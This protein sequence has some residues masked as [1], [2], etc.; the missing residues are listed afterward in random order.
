MQIIAGPAV[1]H[2]NKNEIN[3]WFVLDQK[4]VDVDAVII[5]ATDT[6]LGI[7]TA[8]SQQPIQAGVKAFVYL[9]KLTPK[10][11]EYPVDQLLNYDLRIDG[12][13][14]SHFGLTQGER[15][16]TY[17]GESLPG[18]VLKDKH[19]TILQGSCRKPHAA[20]GRKSQ[21]D[22]MVTGDGLVSRFK[23][24]MVNRP[25]LLFLTG[26]QIYADD[27]AAPLMA[28]IKQQIK[29]YIGHDEA[30]PF[31]DS[32]PITV[33]ALKLN[34]RENLLSQTGLGFSSKHKD[35]QLLSFAEYFIMYCIV[36]GGIDASCPTFVDVE[37]DFNIT[38]DEEDDEFDLI[39]EKDEVKYSYIRQRKIVSQFLT[40]A[41]K[42]RRLM[43]NICSYMI[44]DD[45]EVSD[46]WNLDQHNFNC[47][48]HHVF[49][50]HVQANALAAYWLC[51]GWG[52]TPDAFDQAG[53][54]TPVQDYLLE[55]ES[56]KFDGYESALVAHYWGY[57]INTF[58]YTVVLDTRTQ[59]DYNN[60]QLAKLIRAE[61]L[62]KISDHIQSLPVEIKQDNA[63]LLVSPVPVYGFNSIEW[64]QL[65]LTEDDKDARALDVESWIADDMAF[66]QVQSV[67]RES[68]F[69][70]CAIFSGDV[71]YGFCR[72][73]K[74]VSSQGKAISVFQLT[75]SS[76]HNA[77]G[78]LGG[79]GLGVIA[80]F[81][82]FSRHYSS[83][84]IPKDNPAEFINQ[85]TNI[86]ILTL[87]DGQPTNFKL[88]CSLTGVPDENGGYIWEYDLVR[89]T[90]LR[91]TP[92]DDIWEYEDGF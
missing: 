13:N 59:R 8:D 45:H 76:L 56:T 7:S 18:I 34:D 43:A 57:T 14:L 65:A 38:D 80:T 20:R 2:A 9:L 4:A 31:N 86:G 82:A 44:F 47:F 83:Y 62:A 73:E 50:R 25:T 15:A 63:L 10:A 87:T 49:S 24:D 5:Q 51:Q 88:N 23:S 77:P 22:R 37:N 21:P 79:I 3:I 30:I 17:P 84:L 81:E 6:V 70:S 1:R 75:S 74:L 92:S 35:N 55:Y 90:R 68:G 46:D 69:D 66:K 42:T 71:H 39:T 41:W 29:A 67:I 36:W 48:R 72:H 40:Q 91:Q 26:D 16:I 53:F 60:R 61:H 32:L 28:T 19:S 12:Q 52:N 85:A 64:A 78:V 27:V 58:P 11:D 54:I 33:S 89:R